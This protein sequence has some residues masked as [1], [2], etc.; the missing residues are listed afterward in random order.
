[1]EICLADQHVMRADS[2]LHPTRISGSDS[3]P[4]RSQAAAPPLYLLVVVFLPIGTAL[5]VCASRWS[6]YQQ[7][8]FD[9]IAGSVLGALFAWISFR[10]YHLPLR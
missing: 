6:D 3:I 5:Y 7:E 1:M 2:S 9:I 8:G 10:R 4:P